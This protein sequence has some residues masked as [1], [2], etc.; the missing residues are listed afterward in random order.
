[1]C[2]VHQ[3]LRDNIQKLAGNLPEPEQTFKVIALKEHSQDGSYKVA[4]K[5]E[6]LYE[7]YKQS[8]ANR[9]L[10]VDRGLHLIIDQ[11]KYIL[12]MVI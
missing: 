1:M 10:L 3:K 12:Y 5:D 9:I 6:S 4:W 11:K 7:T 8:D 2:E